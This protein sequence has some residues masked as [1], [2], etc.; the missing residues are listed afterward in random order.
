M[1]VRKPFSRDLYDESDE[2]AKAAVE[3]HL[4][5]GGWATSSGEKYDVDIKAYME[6]HDGWPEIEHHE[7]EVK[8]GWKGD[9]PSCWHDVRIPERKMRLIEHLTYPLY[10]W[11]LS[12]DLSQAWVIPFEVFE[13]APK[14]VVDNKYTTGEKFAIIPVRQ[15]SRVVLKAKKETD[16]EGD[17]GCQQAD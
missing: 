3:Y 9:W 17:T 1:G 4:R 8:H 10:F 14:E 15:A 2:A 11:V 7:V 13:H 6:G 16:H 5:K 12:D